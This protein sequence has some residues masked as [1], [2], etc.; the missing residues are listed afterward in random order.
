MDIKLTTM[1]KELVNF[2]ITK[3]DKLPIRGFSGG[4]SKEL[5][6]KAYVYY[7]G[8][9]NSFQGAGL[10]A[11]KSL[12]EGFY[13]VWFNRKYPLFKY[14]RLNKR[15][16]MSLVNKGIIVEVDKNKIDLNPKFIRLLNSN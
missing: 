1:Q 4:Y 16:V 7:N 2:M 3:H 10:F 11:T 15:T 13:A 12:P 9:I 14:E 6:N 8:T 5:F